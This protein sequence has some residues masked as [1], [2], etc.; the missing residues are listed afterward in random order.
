LLYK[1]FYGQIEISSHYDHT[2]ASAPHRGKWSAKKYALANNFGD[3]V[4]VFYFTAEHDA[5][6]SSK[7]F[8]RVV[9]KP[10]EPEESGR[11]RKDRLFVDCFTFFNELELLK[12]RIKV[13]ASLH[14]IQCQAP[15]IRGLF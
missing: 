8:D 14:T 12:F 11:Q 7:I 10:A 2:E 6:W 15:F 1:Q 9:A 4:G 3:P 13:V 5:T